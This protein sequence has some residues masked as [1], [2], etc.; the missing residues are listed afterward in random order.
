MLGQYIEMGRSTV[1]E[2]RR[3]REVLDR[4]QNRLVNLP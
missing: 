2:F 3:Q 1:A 4:V